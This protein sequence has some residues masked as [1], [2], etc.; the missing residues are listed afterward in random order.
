MEYPPGRIG[1]NQSLTFL[2]AVRNKSFEI[3]ES[4]GLVKVN[5][6]CQF[7]ESKRRP[8]HNAV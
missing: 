1:A 3:I 6:A 4:Y 5:L 2:T 8:P 7:I